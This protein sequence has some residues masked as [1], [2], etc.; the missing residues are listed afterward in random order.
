MKKIILLALLAYSC[1]L[2]AQ[3]DYYWYK[4]QKVYLEKL[5][6]KKFVVFDTY[7]D[8]I[9][10][11]EALHLNNSSIIKFEKN[12]NIS[13]NLNEYETD[14]P[15]RINWAVIEDD[16]FAE[17]N[18]V[19]VIYDAP[20]FMTSNNVEAGLSNLFY[21]KL[22]ISDD[23]VILERLAKENNVEILGNNRFMPLWYTLLCTNNSTGNALSMANFFYETQLFSASEPDLMTDDIVLRD[24][25][26]RRLEYK[27][28]LSA[29][30]K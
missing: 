13:S 26:S 12:N 15:R 16:N 25:Y 27:D 7:N 29:N 21:V 10:L 9:S 22:N 6:T 28:I 23:I 14:I 11:K 1:S 4:G 5:N 2:C 17:F 24:L 3:T 8:S 30:T 19:N 18:R 20:F